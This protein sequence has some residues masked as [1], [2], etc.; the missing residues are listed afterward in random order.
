MS[1][2]DDSVPEPVAN[3]DHTG[4]VSTLPPEEASQVVADIRAVAESRGD[5]SEVVELMDLRPTGPI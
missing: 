4:E 2:P 3:G 5:D 1:A